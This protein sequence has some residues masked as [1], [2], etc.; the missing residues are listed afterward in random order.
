MQLVTQNVNKNRKYI[1]RKWSE[2]L[3]YLQINDIYSSLKCYSAKTFSL[4]SFFF[5]GIQ[6]LKILAYT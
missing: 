1:L 3:M 2:L 6:L 5:I 4:H